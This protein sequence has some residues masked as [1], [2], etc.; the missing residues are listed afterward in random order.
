[1]TEDIPDVRG[2]VPE[3]GKDQ[4]VGLASLAYHLSVS[5]WDFSPGFLT[6]LWH[7]TSYLASPS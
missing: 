3:T 7:L 4:G 1:M 6:A 2:H 5:A